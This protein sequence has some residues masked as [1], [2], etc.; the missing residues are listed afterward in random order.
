VIKKKRFYLLIGEFDMDSTF[1]PNNQA[2]K[3][4]GGALFVFSA[5]IFTMFIV[6]SNIMVTFINRKK[7]K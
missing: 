3:G 7:S 2:T 1:F 4:F 6:M 5:F